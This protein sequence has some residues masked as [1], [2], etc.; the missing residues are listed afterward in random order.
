VP[1]APATANDEASS[2]PDAGRPASLAR[3]P[4]MAV[5]SRCA[6]PFSIERAMLG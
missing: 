4:C 3:K 6:G 5:R 2:I 1:P